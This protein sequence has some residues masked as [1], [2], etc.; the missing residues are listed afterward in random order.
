MKLSTSAEIS[1]PFWKKR[2]TKSCTRVLTAATVLSVA[3]GGVL[4]APASAT[5]TAPQQPAETAPAAQGTA[6]PT[7]SALPEPAPEEASP[8]PSSTVPTQP[9]AP[10]TTVPAEPAP[11]EPAPAAPATEEPAPVEETDKA[12]VED[13]PLEEMTQAQKL[14]LLEKVQGEHGAEMGKGLEMRQEREAE[15]EEAPAQEELAETLDVLE[16][17]RTAAVTIA[18][19]TDRYHWKPSG[20]Q[21]MDVSG[22]QPSVNWQ[23]EWNLGARFAYIKA[24]ESTTYK[25]PSFGSQ[26]TGSYDVGMIRG[27]YHFA[28]PSVT[29]GKTQ[30]DYFVNNGGGWS[31]DGRTLPP[32]LDIEYN[33]YPELGNTCYNMSPSQLVNWVRDFSNQ[34]KVR[35][36]RVPAIYTNGSWWNQ[37][38]G[39]STAFKDHPL[40]IAHF[41]TGNVTYPWLP[42]GWTRYD[43][44]QYSESGPFLGDSN[45][46][47]GTLTQLKDFARYP[48]GVKPATSTVNPVSTTVTSAAPGDLN[49]DGHA[50]LVSRRTDGYLWFYPGNGSG[51][52]GTPVRVGSGWQ[53]YN[54]LIGAG[55]FNGDQYPDLL[56]RHNDGS[57]WFYA[58]TGDGKFKARVKVG[59]SGRNSMTDVVVTG[60]LNEDGRQDLL[61]QHTNGTAYL[62]PGKGTGALGSRSTAGSGWG[63]FTQLIAMQDFDGDRREDVAATRADGTLWLLRGNGAATSSGKLFNAAQKIGSS[64]WQ[65]FQQVLGVGDNNRD[66]KGDI[67]GVN[68][69]KTLR[70][71]AGTGFSEP[72]GYKRGVAKGD[73]VWDEFSQMVA[74]GDYNGDGLA[75]LIGSKPNG[76]L[77]FAPGDGTGSYGTRVKIGNSGWQ[78]YK[79]LTAVGDYN[80]DGRNDLVAVDKDGRLWFYAGTGK[81]GSGS[82]GLRPRV[83]IGSSGWTA[84]TH[85]EGVGDLNR[86]GRNDLLAVQP[87]GNA[88]LYA[89]PGTGKSHGPRT[90]IAS[91]WSG[92]SGVAP[93]SDFDGDGTKDVVFRKADG[94]VWLRTG[95]AQRSGSAWL[96]NERRIGSGWNVYSRVVG[97]G[98]FNRDAKADMVGTRSDGSAWFYA[99]TQFKVSN[100]VRPGINT[101]TL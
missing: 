52:Y 4:V 3:V 28:I 5:D 17:D 27:A 82:E 36:G 94:T 98:D 81:V 85:L 62:Y 86:D 87:S 59:S 101:D 49:M 78:T 19:A 93:V 65:A 6:R 7:S 56:A 40:H 96:S 71:Y 33:P 47:R 83:K 92:Y 57:L 45:V 11:A 22:W 25:N 73:P 99:G 68:S 76:Q 39:S 50:D 37:C 30:A 13:I 43:I 34:I 79:H 74:P 9:A 84:F 18:A 88:Y 31:G 72:E 89:G 21:G 97:T 16:I 58:G 64:G 61:A 1:A 29:S 24:T 55:T 63:A 48:S 69:N 26:Y 35:T 46:W 95:L 75:D 42:A 10:E 70:F 8:A 53:V 80:R 2:L 41:S 44:W 54:K 60:D 32:L 38:L 77:W 12:T 67:L 20:V 91:G 15:L 51:G 23:Y 90:L 100:A 66:G 14:A